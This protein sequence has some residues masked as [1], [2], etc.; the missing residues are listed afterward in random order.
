MNITS[1]VT[2]KEYFKYFCKDE[3]AINMFEK[4][5]E[6]YDLNSKSVLDENS[7]LEYTLSEIEKERDDLLLENQ[8]LH[9]KYKTLL[10]EQEKN[11]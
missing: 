10:G 2:P 5:I 4:Y 9:T 6:E 8:I 1:N 3:I 7:D 11:K